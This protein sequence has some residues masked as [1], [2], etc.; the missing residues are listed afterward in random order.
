MTVSLMSVV[1]FICIATKSKQ[2]NYAHLIPV[3]LD[4]MCTCVVKSWFVPFP[5]LPILFA[6]EER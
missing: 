2:T 1:D 4:V 5:F 6:S 3:V